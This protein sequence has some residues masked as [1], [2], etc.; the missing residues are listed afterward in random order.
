M[1]TTHIKFEVPDPLDS[2]LKVCAIHL[3]RVSFDRSEVEGFDIIE[4]RQEAVDLR[5]HEHVRQK[6]DKYVCVAGLAL[7]QRVSVLN[8]NDCR[9]KLL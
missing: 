5:L 6:F 3:N 1:L 2:Y 9:S 4:V 7:V 8:N